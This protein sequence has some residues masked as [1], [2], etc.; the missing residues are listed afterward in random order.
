MPEPGTYDV[1]ISSEFYCTGIERL[2]KAV[3]LLRHRPTFVISNGTR[4]GGRR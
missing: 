3:A 4:L 1:Q 2:D